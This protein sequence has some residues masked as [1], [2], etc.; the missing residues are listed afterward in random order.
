MTYSD[1]LFYGASILT[2]QRAR[3]LRKSLTPAERILWDVLQNRQM[4]GYKF[5]RQHPIYRYIA[6]FYCHELRLVI[7][8]DGGVHDKVDQQE[9]DS[10]RDLVIREFGIRILRFK[11]EEVVNELERVLERIRAVLP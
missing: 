11:N 1:N 10:N 7:E 5:R 3:E 6:D 2:H 8:L 9:H 4:E